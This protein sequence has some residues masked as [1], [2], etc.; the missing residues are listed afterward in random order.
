MKK[1][2]MIILLILAILFLIIRV[3]RPGNNES[4]EETLQDNKPTLS[5]TE[6]TSPTPQSN[7]TENA[8]INPG[9]NLCPQISKEF[10]T[11]V[12]GIAIERISSLNGPS[13][14]ACDYYLA[15]DTNAPYIAIVVNKNLNFE[16]HKQ[17]AIKNK[18]I[19]KTDA[20]ISGNHYIAWADNET[21]ISNIDVYIDE[22]SFLRIDK[23][24]ER[25]IDN[26]GMIRLASAL[27]KKL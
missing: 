6:S 19:I 15:D 21:R 22:N 9:E 11:D 27:S 17:I 24:V 3:G 18:F 2:I 25:A 7:S 1:Q 12:T 20:R 23:N 13:I 10:V 4:K 16:K 26:E 5:V 14:N 8:K